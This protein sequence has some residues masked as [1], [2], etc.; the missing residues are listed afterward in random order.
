MADD[1][2]F[3]RNR[4]DIEHEN[5]RAAILDNVRER[6]ERS[7]KAWGNMADRTERIAENRIARGTSAS[8][9]VLK[10]DPIGE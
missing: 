7:A 2:S 6:S 5:A 8:A 1:A 3:C 10:S 9:S 4:A